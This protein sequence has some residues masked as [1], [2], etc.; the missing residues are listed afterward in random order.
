LIKSLISVNISSDLVGTAAAASGPLEAID[1]LD[2]EEQHE[3]D[4]Q[5]V[6]RGGD[7]VAIGQD[8]SSRLL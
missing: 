7:K 4:D 5:E 2:Q 3:R 8:R 6:D 1:G